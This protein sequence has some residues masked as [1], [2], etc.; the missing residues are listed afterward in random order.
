MRID[1][2]ELNNFKN[3]TSIK[4]D[5]TSGVNLLVGTNGSG[6]TSLL[7]GL[8]VAVGAFF[9]SQEDLQRKIK[10]DEINITKGIRA[11][12]S[13]I[14]AKNNFLAHQ[15]ETSSWRIYRERDNSTIDK[16]AEKG[17]MEPAFSFGKHI[18]ED[19]F[20]NP[21]DKMRVPLIAYY[22]TQ[23]LFKDVNGAEMLRYDPAKWRRNGYLNCLSDNSIQKVLDEWLGNAVTRRATLQI[24]EINK[25]DQV[26][27]N[28][29]EAIRFTLIDFLDLP[30]DFKLKIYQ[31]PDYNNELYLSFDNEHDLPLSY[32]SDGYR[33]IIYLVIDLFWR[34][35]Q[36]NPWLKF[37]QIKNNVIGVVMIDEIDLHLHPVWQAK[38][39]ALLQKLLPNVQF[40]I[41]THSPTVIANFKIRET[42]KEVIDRLYILDGEK[43]HPI[44]QSFY[45]QDVNSILSNA[46]NASTRPKEILDK[47]KNFNE[48]VENPESPEI[49]YENAKE[50]AD[51]LQK[52]LPGTDKEM[53][54]INSILERLNS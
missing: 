25:T 42:E 12:K 36:L 13:H 26:L 54:R 48:I 1:H 6:K 50:I 16:H 28:V 51:Q 10:F 52:I 37:D 33:N 39:V 45:G 38:A 22:S 34:A 49:D 47:I 11:P 40:F 8:C 46:M 2:L 44:E 14:T 32:Y 30:A 27:E 43:L 4:A 35:S 3:F 24:K 19:L 5:F 53:I 21:E 20:N 29:E 31:D 23:R 9:G 18:F 15:R 41:T 7:E 17:Y